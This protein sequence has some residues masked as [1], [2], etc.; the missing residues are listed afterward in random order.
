MEVFGILAF[1]LALPALGI[2]VLTYIRV[3]DID[4][5]LKAHET[6]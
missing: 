2:A 3:D 4:K 5:R 1:T 6:D